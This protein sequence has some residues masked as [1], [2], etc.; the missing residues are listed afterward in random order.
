MEEESWAPRRVVRH[1]DHVRVDRRD[2]REGLMGEL[3]VQVKAGAV[4]SGE[5][6]LRLVRE[7]RMVWRCSYRVLAG[8]CSWRMLRRVF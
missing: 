3:L 7:D 6:L 1:E 5:Q 8:V 2:E 4:V